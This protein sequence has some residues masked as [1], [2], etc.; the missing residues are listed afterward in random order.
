M[1]EG[2]SPEQTGERIEDALARTLQTKD[3]RR[4]FLR[5]AAGAAGVVAVGSLDGDTRNSSHELPPLF[6]Q[7]DIVNPTP[8]EAIK[9]KPPYIP[10][11]A[12]IKAVEDMFE[13]P[14]LRKV[15]VELDVEDIEKEQTR[16]ELE[17]AKKNGLTLFD[18]RSI[19]KPYAHDV[20]QNEGRNYTFD[21]L[22]EA[23][24][25][26][27]TR[28]G[29]TIE[30][31]EPKNAIARS[32]QLPKEKLETLKSKQA[33]VHFM[34]EIGKH[35]VEFIKEW[36]LKKIVLI[37]IADPKVGGYADVVAG[38]TFL[39][40]P[41]KGADGYG[42]THESYHLYDANHS[43]PTSHFYDKAYNALN[44]KD[45]R[46]YTDDEMPLPKHYITDSVYTDLEIAANVQR[47]IAS[48]KGDEGEV[49]RIDRELADKAKHVIAVRDY[50]L[51]NVPED[52]A[53]MGS[54]I[55]DP[56]AVTSVLD[57]AKPVLRQKALL[58]L[59][60]YYHDNPALVQF[61]ADTRV[62]FMEEK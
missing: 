62:D 26:F 50:S 53:D 42:V 46:I 60:R 8:T 58:L 27:F 11:D 57:K 1:S 18:S 14:S 7:K 17:A 12:E 45:E 52:K 5:K 36:G 6:N 23:A 9:E 47:R 20:M 38:D 30:F 16:I 61:I 25:D 43:G 19:I 10:T 59:A 4:G 35:P 15:S 33:I 21:Q 41:T 24:R 55:S 22:L 31:E 39:I 2:S 34:E 54:N 44:P 40:D 13:R 37:S 49:A 32:R 56:L 51:T 28:Y 29:V 48:E 3:T